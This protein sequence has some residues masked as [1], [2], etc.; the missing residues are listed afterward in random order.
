M[1]FNINYESLVLG[2]QIKIQ[3]QQPVIK[4]NKELFF[5]IA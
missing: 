3:D 5:D 2:G 1:P 4:L